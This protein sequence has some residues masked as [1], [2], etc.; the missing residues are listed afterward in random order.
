MPGQIDDT[1]VR[2][3]LFLCVKR[4]VEWEDEYKEEEGSR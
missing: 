3:A 4:K 1:L 2:R